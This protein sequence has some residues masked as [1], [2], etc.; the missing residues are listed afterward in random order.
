MGGPILQGF[1][2]LTN[3]RSIVG[4]LFK[5]CDGNRVHAKVL[6]GKDL[7]QTG[8]CAVSLAKD[9]AS[10]L[11]A[12]R[13]GY[14][15]MLVARDRGVTA[16]A[17]AVVDAV[18][19]AERVQLER[20]VKLARANAG[21][22]TAAS[23]ARAIRLQ[24]GSAYAVAATEAHR[25][26]DC[27]RRRPP[28]VSAPAVRRSKFREF[29]D[30][31]ASDLMVLADVKGNQAQL[32]NEVDMVTT[33]QLVA[34]QADKKPITSW[35]ALLT[36][37]MGWAGPPQ[38][39]IADLG[40]F[41]GEFRSELEGMGAELVATAALGPA[42]N[43]ICERRGGGWK[44]IIDKYQ[45]DFTV[46]GAVEWFCTVV[47]WATSSKVSWPSSLNFS[48]GDQVFYWRGLSKAEKMWNFKRYGPGV[49]I[50]NEGGNVWV[51]HQN[52]TLKSSPPHMRHALPEECVPWNEISDSL[53]HGDEP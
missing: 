40:E 46:P 28:G 32:Q 8:R 43:G 35:T 15:V 25:C 16:R 33:F 19:P 1:K 18:G 20:A 27:E 37:W 13:R 39:S 10:G 45:V 4:G 7:S 22:P 42:Q 38:A 9:I 30:G 34:P 36:R 24:R 17:E 50:G 23:L 6:G 44:A 51:S 3:R 26:P 21:H 31:V 14:D 29:G 52:A 5:K 41:A 12:V 49:V 11:R 48:I 2:V 53:A 47:N